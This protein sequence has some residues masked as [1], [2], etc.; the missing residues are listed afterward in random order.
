MSDNKT[1]NG[2][3]NYETWCA[4]L[5]MDNAGYEFFHDMAREAWENAPPSYSSQSKLD[6]ARAS[7][8]AALKEYHEEEMPEVVGVY[9]DLLSAALSEVDW[10]EIAGSMLEDFKEEEEEEEEEADPPLL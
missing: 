9:S 2:W 7:L 5:W 10:Y 3:T 1:Y 6:A 8:A 4:N